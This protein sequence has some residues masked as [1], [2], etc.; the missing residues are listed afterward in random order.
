MIRLFIEPLVFLPDSLKDLVAQLIGFGLK[1]AAAGSF[2][3]RRKRRFDI[4]GTCQG[5]LHVNLFV[6]K[7]S[8]VKPAP[9]PLQRSLLLGRDPAIRAS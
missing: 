5:H 3:D 1:L 4:F 7:Q 6:L 9:V 8:I 2:T